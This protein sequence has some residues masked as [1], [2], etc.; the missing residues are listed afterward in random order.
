M[1]RLTEKI[2]VAAAS[3]KWA[4]KVFPNEPKDVAVDKLWNAIFDCV[5]LKDGEDA[6]KIWQAHNERMTKKANWLMNRTLN[7]FIIP[8]VT[9]RILQ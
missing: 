2:N 5:Y 3:E 6:E 7:L 9:E 4:K 8:V 1:T